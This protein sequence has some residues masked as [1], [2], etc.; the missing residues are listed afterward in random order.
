MFAPL[1]L[2]DYDGG[3]RSGDEEFSDIVLFRRLDGTIGIP[4][5]ALLQQDWDT[6]ANNLLA[7]CDSPALPENIAAKISVRIGVSIRCFSVVGDG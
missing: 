5:G 2:S 6:I 4:L 3:R 7:E 1:K